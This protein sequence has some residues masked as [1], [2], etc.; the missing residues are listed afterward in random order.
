M[1]RVVS[2]SSAVEGEDDAFLLAILALSNRIAQESNGQ[3]QM[4]NGL[5]S[6]NHGGT[7]LPLALPPMWACVQAASVHEAGYLSPGHHP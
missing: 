7:P 6:S 5:V 1:L 2:T 3:G 4:P